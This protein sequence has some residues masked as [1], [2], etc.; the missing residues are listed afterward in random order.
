MLPIEFERAWHAVLMAYHHSV[1]HVPGHVNHTRDGRQIRPMGLNAAAEIAGLSKSDM[2]NRLNVNM[3]EHRPTLE[4][5]VLHLL[6]GMDTEALDVLERAMGRV[7]FKL[8]DL[9]DHSDLAGDLAKVGKEFG[10]VCSSMS[11]ALAD[12][13]VTRKEAEAFSAEVDDN[14][15]ALAE[16]REAMKREVK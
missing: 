3:P 16:L 9:A 6:S 11:A 12:G 15:A 1:V 13:K 14:I 5:F 2:S 4:G 8:P 10:K 7:A